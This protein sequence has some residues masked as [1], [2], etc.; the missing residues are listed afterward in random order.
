[1]CKTSK[2]GFVLSIVSRVE[3]WYR[4]GLSLGFDKK[5]LKLV[6][7]PLNNINNKII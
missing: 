3:N 5:K 7:L 6:Q 2:R 1:M 4:I